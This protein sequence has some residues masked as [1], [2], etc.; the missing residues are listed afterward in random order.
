MSP[1]GLAVLFGVA[2]ILSAVLTPVARTIGLRLG[3][4]DMPGRLSI[5]AEPTARTGG[6]AIIAAFGAACAVWVLVQ[7]KTVEGEALPL[8]VLVTSSALSGVVGLL[9]D[10]A[11][12]T[13]KVEL[14]LLFFPAALPLV[15]GV[16]VGLITVGWVAIPLS[17]FYFVGGASAMNLLDGMDGLAAGIAA[18]AA[19]FFAFLG[20]ARRDP[21][22]A[23]LAIGLCGSA[24]G[25]LVH[26][27]HPASVFMGDV[28]SLFLGY[29][30]A[31]IMVLSSA[32][33]HDLPGFVGPIVIVGV[34][35]LDTSLAIAR[36]VLRG[37]DIMY[38]D[39]AHLYD[40]LHAQ[41]LSPAATV[42]LTYGLGVLFG[43]TGLLIVD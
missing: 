20:I 26:N 35:V 5:H 31:A 27:L 2:F 10:L 11:W 4:L 33:P 41:G 30:L 29:T 43:M 32:R 12:I 37:R 19:A 18:I 13:P 38:G 21:L 39:R 7:G 8:L 40:W 1:L 36:R 15:F 24:L 42:L 25:F 16:R 6:L 28:G 14:A 22:I 9:D 34:P 23:V 3:I 17:L